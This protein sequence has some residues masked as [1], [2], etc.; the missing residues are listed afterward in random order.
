M[1][2]SVFLKTVFLKNRTALSFFLSILIFAILGGCAALGGKKWPELTGRILEEVQDE[3][4]TDAII[5][6]LWKGKQ[7]HNNAEKT[8][9]YHVETTISDGK[10]RFSIPDWRESRQHEALKDKTIHLTAFKRGHR[11]SELTTTIYT[12]K[13]Y[14]YYLADI[15]YNNSEEARKKRLKYLQLLIG[16]T[17]CDLKG[18]SKANLRPLYEAIVAEA[19]GIAITNEDDSVVKRLKTWKSFVQNNDE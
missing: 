13:R 9:C 2:L 11:T 1:L 16:K 19:E 12:G 7:K 5:V 14:V 10:G 8:I 18:E 3:P 17:S 4:V 15:N 6:A